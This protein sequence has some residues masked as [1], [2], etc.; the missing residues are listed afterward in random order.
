[1]RRHF[2]FVVIGGG[3]AGYAAARTAADA[4]RSVAIVDSG[5]EL[6]GLCILRGC[7]PS[8][9][10]LHVADVLHHA[11]TAGKLG[12][13][14]PSAEADM[15]A[16]QARKR[17]IIADFASYRVE[18]LNSDRFTLIRSK[19]RFV[20]EAELETEDGERIEA[21]HFVV[22]T[23]SLVNWPEVPGLEPGRIW[24]SD[25]VLNLDYLPQSVVVLGGGV[26]A[27]EL[28]QFLQRMG[29]KVTLVQRSGRILKECSP[30]AAAVVEQAFRD[31]GMDVYTGTKL[32][33]VVD[34]PTRSGKLV[35]FEWAGEM[36]EVSAAHVMNAMGRRPATDGLN[37]SAAG[38]NL[39]KQGRIVVDEFQ[40]S[41]NPRIYAAG[42]VC[43]PVEIVHVAI[44]QGELAAGHATGAKFELL[45]YD[46]VTRVVFTSPQV[47][48][49]GLGA[50]E[51]NERGIIFRE[52]SYPFDD[53]GKSIL[54]EAKYGYVRIMA[55]QDGR[56]LGA[57]CVGQDAGELIHPLVVAIALG[58]DCKSLLKAQWYHPTLSEI[59]TYP[60]EDLA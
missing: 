50:E 48:A 1:M 28:A 57:E 18:Q 44:M 17:E 41:T 54:M 3:S 42:D 49:A 5:S 25:D 46:K 8:K 11:R 47:A 29:A 31:E 53:H 20:S 36:V 24:T 60:L 45:D 32:I 2:D 21:E 10:L 43:G 37:L 6:A 35:R 30:E 27:C 26:V 16:V 51:L 58:A 13:R 9:T 14:I 19:V 59:W 56:I 15:V 12:L 7:M 52:E 33:A 22:A 23:G 39:D 55:G 4:G 38:V 34:D 40:R